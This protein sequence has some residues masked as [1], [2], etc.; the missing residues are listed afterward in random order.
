MKKNY[1]A[2]ILIFHRLPDDFLQQRSDVL[3]VFIGNKNFVFRTKF[4]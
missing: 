1:L 4:L 2:K 3:S